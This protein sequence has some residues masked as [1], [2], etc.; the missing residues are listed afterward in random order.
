[1]I[2]RP[3]SNEYAPY[4]HAYIS[5][6]PGND[7]LSALE[8]SM[9]DTLSFF[10]ALP[11]EKWNHS[12]AAGKWTIKQILQHLI[13][14]ERVFAYRAL[15]IARGDQTPLPGFDENE[16]ARNGNANDLSP[17]ELLEEYAAVRQATL[18]LFK[19]MAEEASRNIGTANHAPFSARAFGFAIA[20]HELHHRSVIEERYL[21][22]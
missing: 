1:M 21:Q 11:A 7:L 6:V 17:N 22:Q 16:F 12:Y 15:T 13:D 9:H 3:N 19:N 8:S 18:Y 5:K 4:C 2:T 20:G 10:R 14:S